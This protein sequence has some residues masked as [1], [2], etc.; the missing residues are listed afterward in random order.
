[1]FDSKFGSVTTRYSDVA[2]SWKDNGNV[3][4]KQRSS[5][6]AAGMQRSVLGAKFSLRAAFR[7]SANFV[8]G[9][10]PSPKRVH[11]RASETKLS[12]RTRFQERVGFLKS[13]LTVSPLS[14]E[15]FA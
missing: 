9:P 11:V 8:T 7:A 2:T 1:M 13:G 5:A 14:T 3:S 15:S 12:C 10:A 6:A 4:I